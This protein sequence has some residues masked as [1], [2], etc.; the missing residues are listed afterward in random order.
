MKVKKI[1]AKGRKYYTL[2]YNPKSKK[3]I[4]IQEF[5]QTLHI[6]ESN[7]DNGKPRH[8]TRFIISFKRNQVNLYQ[9]GT[10]NRIVNVTTTPEAFD[11]YI[12]NSLAFAKTDKTNK[13]FLLGKRSA[14]NKLILQ[15]AKQC[16]IRTLIKLNATRF[17]SGSLVYIL[18][19]PLTSEFIIS[20]FP[21]EIVHLAGSRKNP[22]SRFLRKF[23]IREA[24]ESGLKTKSKK[25]IKLITESNNL[26]RTFLFVYTLRKLIPLDYIFE[27]ILN[28]TSQSLGFI[29]EQ[30][31]RITRKLLKNYGK[32]RI[33]ILMSKTFNDFEL[34]DSA[35]QWNDFKNQ[36][37]LPDK[38]DSI[39]TLHDYISKEYRKV[40]TQNHKLNMIKTFKI[41]DGFQIKNYRFHL[42]KN[43]HELIEWGQKLNNC[44][45]SYSDSAM[46]QDIQLVGVL[47]DDQLTYA[48]ELSKQGK[49]IQFRGKNNSSPD[50]SDYKL[51][52]HTIT[53]LLTIYP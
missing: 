39:K 2:V 45:A 44:I 26:Y 24:V 4:F 30:Q 20:R 52:T 7:T 6:R 38:P 14:L 8:Q 37:T 29:N 43:T 48:L 40:K 27:I 9:K 22:I 34:I 18:A 36:I 23:S 28:N 42:P 5:P 53:N 19:F 35:K 3:T 46:R 51:I 1:D 31:V 12:N 50:L 17:Y 49:I 25:L 47:K 11:K 32:E 13:F 10:G 41:L 33:K 21:K 15:K 16:K